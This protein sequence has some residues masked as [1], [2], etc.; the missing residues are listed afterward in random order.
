MFQEVEAGRGGYV[1]ECARSSSVDYFWYRETLNISTSID[2]SGS[3][4]WWILLALTCAWSVLYVCT[5]RGIETTGKRLLV[6]QGS[7][8]D[9]VLDQMAPRHTLQ[10]PQAGATV[11]PVWMAGAE[12][13][14]L[15]QAVYIT[16]TLPYVVLTIFLIR[17]LT[18]KGATNGIVF[19]FTP[20]VTELAN[21]VTWL[22]A[23]AQVFYSFSLA[24]GGLI[25]FSSY[26]P[27]QAIQ[28]QGQTG[29]WAPRRAPG[30]TPATLQG[31]E[32]TGLAFIVFTEA[33]TKMPVAPLWSV[34]FFIMLFCLGL[35][36]MFGNMEGVVV[37]LQDLKVIPKKWPKELLTALPGVE[38]DAASDES[39]RIQPGSSTARWFNRDIEFMIGHKPNIFWQVTWRVVSPLLMLAIFLFFFVI[40]VREELTYNIWDPGY[41]EFPKS[42]EIKYPGWVYAVVVIVAGVPCLVI[43]CFAIYKL[44][45]NFFQRPGDQRALRLRAAA[46][47]AG[48]PG[49]APPAEGG[50]EAR[51][52]WDNKL[53]YLLSC[54]GFAVGL[55]NLWRFPYLCQ[56]Y[57]GGEP[58][59]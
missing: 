39:P 1:E 6:A 7:A 33:I 18:L 22:D 2:D 14:H 35:S 59:R 12:R 42:K 20:N 21:P 58:P 32:G 17:G 24:F 31:V 55:G 28:G 30:D 34:L 51:P 45:R 41:E 23:G 50:G 13:C 56:T 4:Q 57:G 27:V 49:P 9:S 5:I 8:P 15:P 46:G 25:S 36:S 11:V 26:N 48:A 54:V 19:L 44:I 52:A 47:M 3:V 38:E 29:Q 40:K 16:S 53:Q 43:P 10:K 37:P